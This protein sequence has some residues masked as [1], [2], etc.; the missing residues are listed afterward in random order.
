MTLKFQVKQK[1]L[2][3][4]IF[5]KEKMIY[6]ANEEKVKVLKVE[7]FS[8]GEGNPRYEVSGWK[9]KRK[10]KIEDVFP[11]LVSH[12]LACGTGKKRTKKKKEK[13]K[14]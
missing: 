5:P 11:V 14:Y 7:W 1:M 12:H 8:I 3:S 6:N 4:C 13:A 2:N 10:E 9:F